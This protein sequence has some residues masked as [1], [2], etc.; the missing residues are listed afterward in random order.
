MTGYA[1]SRA[2]VLPAQVQPSDRLGARWLRRRTDGHNRV[3]TE[4]RRQTTASVNDIRESYPS[5]IRLDLP[6]IA[7][8]ILRSKG[9]QEETEKQEQPFADRLPFPAISTTKRLW[10]SQAF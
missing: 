3:L 9:Q 7:K 4:Q 6:A 5:P 1:P 10:S 8:H 2:E